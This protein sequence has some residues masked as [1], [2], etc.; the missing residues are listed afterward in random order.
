LVVAAGWAVGLATMAGCG[1]EDEVQATGGAGAGGETTCDCGADVNAAAIPLACACEA[2]LCTT[3]AEDLAMY[4]R[5][6]HLADPNYVLLGTCD[7]GY[8][9][10]RYE[11]A[12]EQSRQHTYDADGHMVYDRFGGYG[13]LDMPKACGFAEQLSLGSVTVGDDSSKNCSYCLVT[14]H[15]EGVGEGAGGAGASASPYYPESLTAPCDP[16]LLE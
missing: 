8:R 6:G 11:E 3:F 10:L 5:P 15:D 14:A 9:T 12:T 1:D 16:S 13:P 4:Q 7:G 2:G